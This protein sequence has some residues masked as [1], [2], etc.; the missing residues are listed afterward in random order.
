MMSEKPNDSRCRLA[1]TLLELLIVIAIIG[2]CLGLLIPGVQQAREAARRI[3]CKSN[4]REISHGLLQFET[5]NRSFP[6]SFYGKEDSPGYFR[7]GS[8]MGH[9]SVLPGILGSNQVSLIADQHKLGDVTWWNGPQAEFLRRSHSSLFLCPSDGERGRWVVAT[10]TPYRD[11]Y[12]FQ[13]LPANVDEQWTNYLGCSGS[14][15]YVR[16][17]S[18]GRGVFLPLAGSRMRD[19]LDGTSNTLF[20]GE[21]TGQVRN[22]LQRIGRESSFS[23][24]AGAQT[25]EEGLNYDRGKIPGQDF[26]WVQFRS[27][28]GPMV[29]FSFV[30]GRVEAIHENIDQRLLEAM[31]TIAD[32]EIAIA[33]P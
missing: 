12:S 30:D 31:A 10:I 4:L 26:G 17:S 16:S 25:V 28:H 5:A 29:H 22:S 11:T 1:F 27:M 21:V 3:A 9:L 20:L 13:L 8:L 7:N 33:A 2:V 6:P 14:R 32:H 15:S 23:W 19:I 18:I 24:L